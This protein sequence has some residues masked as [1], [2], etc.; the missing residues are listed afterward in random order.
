MPTTITS[1]QVNQIVHNLHHD[2]FE[3]LGCH[4]LSEKKQSKTMGN[5]SL[6][7]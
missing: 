3:I 7:T 4:L 5:Q 2:P 1:E 6:F